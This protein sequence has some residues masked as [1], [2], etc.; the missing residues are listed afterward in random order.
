MLPVTSEICEDR[1]Q[2]V[3]VTITYENVNEY[4]EEF[5][6]EHN[7]ATFPSNNSSN[8]IAR[9]ANWPSLRRPHS[10]I[11]ANIA[12]NTTLQHGATQDATYM[13]TGVPAKAHGHISKRSFSDRDLRRWC[14]N[15]HHD[16]KQQCEQI[17]VHFTDDKELEYDSDPSSTF[18]LDKLRAGLHRDTQRTQS[19]KIS[20]LCVTNL[21]HSN[22]RP[23][24][25]MGAYEASS[26]ANS[27]N[28][29]VPL[30]KQQSFSNSFLGSSQFLN[31]K[32]FMQFEEEHDNK[33]CSICRDELVKG[34]TMAKLLCGHFFH[35]SCLVQWLLKNPVCPNCRE[36]VEKFAN[37]PFL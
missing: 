2:K 22:E 26:M 7:T 12:S 27:P 29:P 33:M 20:N 6:Y 3:N 8:D 36:E 31:S 1:T 11:P 10:T 5:V 13:N 17:P 18:V 9:A 16:L 32:V 21:E 23:V 19:R 15:A 4:V 14:N 28:G 25:N 35:K 37:V 24:H 30:A 34:D